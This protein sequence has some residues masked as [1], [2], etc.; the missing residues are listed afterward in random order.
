MFAPAILFQLFP[1]PLMA[2]NRRFSFT[3]RLSV[4]R[5]LTAKKAIGPVVSNKGDA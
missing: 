3:Q 5:L 1:Q 4:A 2:T